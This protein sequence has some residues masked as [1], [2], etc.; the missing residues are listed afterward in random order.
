MIGR[1]SNAPCIAMAEHEFDLAIEL[2]VRLLAV[3]DDNNTIRVARNQLNSTF[4]YVSNSHAASFRIRSDNRH[5]KSITV[6][7][8]T[9]LFPLNQVGL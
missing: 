8:F 9:Q 7:Y 5:K 6:T 1:Y 4:K 3:Q 2:L